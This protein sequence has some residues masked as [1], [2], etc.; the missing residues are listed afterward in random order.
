VRKI[1]GAGRQGGKR[2]GRTGAAPPARSPNPAPAVVRAGTRA[3]PLAL[4]LAGALLLVAAAPLSGA[5]PGVTPGVG[6]AVAAPHAPASMLPGLSGQ[7]PDTLVT[8]ADSLRARILERVRE[9]SR[10]AETE[11]GEERTRRPADM[12]PGQTRTGAPGQ[13]G[14]VEGPGGVAGGLIGPAQA[15][16]GGAGAGR[17]GTPPAD[18]P[19]PSGADSIMQ[20][21]AGLPGFTPASFEGVRAEYTSGE[22]RL[23]LLGRPAPP[24]AEG[25]TAARPPTDPEQPLPEA[26]QGRPARFFGQGVRVEADSSI[27]FD[28]RT[29][30]VRTQG[31]TLLTP[32]RGDPVRSRLLVYDVNEA[33]GSA[34]GAETTY[35]EGGGEWIVR[36]DLTSVRDGEIYG[37]RARFTS[38]DRPEPNSYFEASEIK[39]LANQILVARSVRLHFSDV[40]V[41]WLPFLAQPLQS[42]RQ[43]GL[44]TPRFSVNDIVRT[45]GGYERRISN[46]GIYWAMSDFSDATL[47]GDWWSG[48]Y[49]ALTGSLRFRWAERFLQGEISAR[50]FWRE[51]GARDLALSTRNN[52]EPTERTRVNVAGNF[53]SN[54]NLVR[55]NSLDPRELTSSINSTAGVQQRF[56]WGSMSVEARRQQY[57]TDDRLEMTLPSATLRLNSFTLL[58]ETPTR[59]RW[60][61]NMT[62]NASSDLRR[63]VREFPLPTGTGAQAFQFS[64]TDNIRT[65][66]GARA[67]LGIG[68]LSLGLDGTYQENAFSNVPDVLGRPRDPFPILQPGDELLDGERPRVD[69]SDALLQWSASVGY[70]QR[71]IGTSTITPSLSLGGQMVRVDSI[72]EARD[73]VQGPTR[74]SFNLGLQTELYGFFPGFAGFEAIRHKVTPQ[75]NYTYAPAITPTD[76]QRRVFGAGELRVQNRF[77][78]G[79]SQTFEARAPEVERSTPGRPPGAPPGAPAE[80]RE[81]PDAPA[82]DDPVDPVE[83]APLP[84]DGIPPTEGGLEDAAFGDALRP[85]ALDDDGDLRRPPPSRTITLLALNTQALGYDL[86]QADSTGQWLDGFTTLSLRN[87]VRSDFLRGLDFS[88]THDLWQEPDSLRDR[89]AFSPHLRQL[90]LGFSLD[91]NTGI[92][93][94]LGRRVGL[95]G[96]EPPGPATGARADLDDQGFDEPA[97]GFDDNRVLPGLSGRGRRAGPS[98]MHQQGWKARL[99]YAL[100][101]PRSGVGVSQMLNANVSFRPTELLSLNWTTAYDLEEQRFTDHMVTVM[102]DMYDWEATFGFRQAVNG[103][104]TFRF[105]V[106]LKANR[107]LRFDHETRNVD[108]TAGFGGTGGLG[109]GLAF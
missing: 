106:S 69:F 50:R 71:L 63:D 47:A 29:G 37:T 76:L 41:A 98:M 52:W 11:P 25:D 45:S 58:P 77:T 96:D 72:A 82:A 60:F 66:G 2:E 18:A 22:G 17:P 68:N 84:Q 20:R 39:V 62:V 55:Q 93:R 21:L 65:R 51:T 101:R 80:E 67:S 92:L 90:A 9:Q 13:T 48:Q 54:T 74:V 83:E 64:R 87:T 102:R 81:D 78:L 59:A 30:R 32:E 42:G 57:L 4:A 49:S 75:F 73:F 34:M 109:G 103:N 3:R 6:K 88:F 40:P 36:G 28:D 91:A 5:T 33:R 7:Q 61:N 95:V 12:A 105:E 38:D 89:R 31:S 104:W 15:F 108:G 99:N 26:A 70:Q 86:V 56:G 100:Q 107:D 85:S 53:V 24:P 94:A 43:S 35:A 19:L 44:L 46:V 16:G 97:D 14:R 10:P 23:L 27:T 79:F 1:R 8:R